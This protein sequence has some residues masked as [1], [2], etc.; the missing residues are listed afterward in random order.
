MDLVASPPLVPP[1]PRHPS[2][3]AFSITP[4]IIY[5]SNRALTHL[6]ESWLDD[7]VRLIAQEPHLLPRTR[8]VFESATRHGRLIVAVDAREHNRAVGCVA[9]WELARDGLDTPWYELGT[10]VVDPEYRYRAQGEKAMPMGDMLYRLMLE[11][12]RRLN[13]L[14]TA[15]NPSEIKT[16]MRHEMKMLR[17]QMLPIKVHRASCVCPKDRTQ[18]DNNMIC[19]LRNKACRVRVTKETWARMGYPSTLSYP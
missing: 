13:I 10:F 4:N 1:T 2:Q 19:P 15:T 14:A 17:F 12:H 5:H 3:S 11:R 16:G 8:E 6:P 18:V 7:L 9:L